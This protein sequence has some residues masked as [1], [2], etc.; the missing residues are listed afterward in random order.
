[1]TDLA[2]GCVAGLMHHHRGMAGLVAPTV[3]SYERLKPASLSG[4]WRNWG[5]DH[6]G[7]T[8]RLSAETAPRHGWSIG[9]A[10][11]PPIPTHWSRR[12]CTLR[13]S[14]SP[15]NTT[16]RRRGPPTAS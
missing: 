12:F 11:P 1:M 10:M 2:K 9:W 4:Y 15:G 16:C 13:G 6:R 5:I 7:V 14:A 3:N 8:T